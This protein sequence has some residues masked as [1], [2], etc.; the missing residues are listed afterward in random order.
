MN[1]SQAAV[2]PSATAVEEPYV[3]LTHF[4][5]EYFD[6]FFGREKESALVIGN[7]RAAR[8]TL[9]YAESGVG[10]SSVLR[11]G[12]VARLREFAAG[13]VEGRGSP[14][15]VPVVFSSWS[16]RP[17]AGLV[18]AIREAI[19]PYL[20]DGEAPELPADDLEAALEAAGQALDATVLVILD[21]FE[22]YFLY[23]DEEPEDKR[24]AA[25]IARCVNRRDLRA[26]FLISIREDAYA[27]LGDLFRGK[28]KNVY[29]N[30]LHLDFLDRVGAREAIE[31]PL[32]R[33]NELQPDAEPFGVEPAL[34]EA[35]LD[36]VSRDEEGKRIETTYLQLVMRRL[37]GEET[38][39][40]SRVLRLRTLERLG[41][42]QA[43]IGS[44]LDRAMEADA[45]GAG[46]LS[47][48]QRRT[49]ATIFRFLVTSGGTKI[50]LT[51]RDLADLSGL[52][53]PE[54]DPVLQH[55]SSPRL[56]ILRPVV[57]D[58]EGSAP[59]FEIFHDALAGPIVEWRTEVEEE[60]REARA[61][62]ER[63]EKEEAQRAAVAAEQQAQQERRRKQVAQGLLAL[64]VVALLAGAAVF[65]V[66]QKN[67]ADQRQADSESVQVAERISEL[68]QV[69]SFGPTA[70][71]LAS[72]EAYRL[73]PTAEARERALAQLQLSPALPTMMAGHTGAVESVAYWPDSNKLASGGDETVRL[74]R[75]DGRP[76]NAPL[77]ADGEVLEVAVS[78]ARRGGGRVIAAGLGSKRVQLWAVSGDGE[79]EFSKAI[80][81]SR[82][83]TKGVAF[84]P[85]R[86]DLLVTGGHDGK[87]RLWSVK[88]PR[89]ARL[90]DAT[91]IPGEIEDVAFTAD[92]R[93]LLVAGSEGSYE[94]R[95]TGA[96]F[97]GAPVRKT[98][99]ASAVAAA[100]D[101]SYAFGG[102]G[103]GGIELWPAGGAKIRLRQPGKVYGLAFAE[104]GSV[105]VS[106]GSD[107]NVTTW[108]VKTGRPF[109][110]PWGANRAA[111]NDVAISPDGRSVAAAGGDR[112]VKV[113]AL[114]PSQPPLASVVGGLSPAEAGHSAPK[115]YDLVVGAGGRIATPI[116]PRGTSVWSLRSLGEPDAVP[117]PVAHLRGQSLDAAYHG[118][119]LVTGRGSSFVV[120]G[121]REACPDGRTGY[122]KLAA[123]PPKPYSRGTASGFVFAPYGNRLLLASLG[124]RGKRGILNLWDLTAAG[125]GGK[126]VH[127]ASEETPTHLF[128]VSFDPK[129]P[130]IAAAARN[131]GVRLWDISDLHDP[132]PVEPTHRGEAENQ[133]VLSVAFSPDGSLL[134]SGGR[135]QQVTLWRVSEDGAGAIAGRGTP[136]TLLQRQTI[137]ALAFGPG[138]ETLA[139]A[140][141]G[142]NICLYEVDNR[143]LIGDRS[144]LRGYNTSVFKQNGGIEAMRFVRLS[145]G[146]T[147]LLTAGRGQPIVA[148][149]S[150]LWNLSDSTGVEEAIARDVCALAGRNL[151]PDE[152]SAAF[153]ST[154]FAGDPHETCE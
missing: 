20:A 19:R 128:E 72:V 141:G 100:P 31:K 127:L 82:G 145:S 56:H 29:G 52:S 152:W 37:W 136:G 126:V 44:H 78:A 120:Y 81:G 96:G 48:E 4:I 71:A 63:A 92:G 43:I 140:D 124:R 15:L 59:R 95:L 119:V 73:A 111:I 102:K 62:G 16:E 74:W 51:A 57:F 101:G 125:H 110:A 66:K 93:G 65:A 34:V 105:L 14:R 143:H 38:A 36:Q 115:I 150:L 1:A 54:I 84:D 114:R 123:P 109:G 99:E 104:G 139:A 2:P 113:W 5:E 46:G 42:A 130:L 88:E 87:L 138:G 35:V 151:T 89:D 146:A 107:W 26:N 45:D 137:T 12:A 21:Q 135:N 11:A 61:A 85:R 67:L 53:L 106:G 58:G 49:A 80:A 41:G 7:L 8:L 23:P 90:L 103:K 79:E 40:G 3:G 121:T 134:A 60:A 116:G 55:L 91:E 122:C 6:R 147:V 132:Q 32:E 154:S 39:A 86:P 129:H 50:A 142:G 22:E 112:L 77:V 70:A 10:K 64:A 131:G 24:I 69:P 68:A 98:G 13:D 133:A 9:L 118:N 144:C 148:W 108:D 25:Q 117:H 97:A 17:V 94:L 47:D 149:S 30:F 76:L 153:A 33:V 75:P 18:Q 27:E 83:G 28:V